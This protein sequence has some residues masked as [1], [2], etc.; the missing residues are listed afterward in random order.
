MSQQVSTT[1][2]LAL[3]P[4]HLLLKEMA[5]LLSVDLLVLM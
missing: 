2:R 1:L 3:E 5:T 4:E